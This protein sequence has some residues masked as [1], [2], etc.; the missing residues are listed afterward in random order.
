[1][2]HVFDPDIAERYGVN[3]AIILHSIAFWVDINEKNERNY[4]D[5]RYWTYNSAKAFKD[6]FPYMSV[7]T[8]QRVLKHLIDE[9]LILASKFNGDS[10]NRTNYYALTDYGASLTTNWRV[11]LRQNGNM[12]NDKV[13]TSIFNNN[14]DNSTDIKS[15]VNNNILSPDVSVLD[16]DRKELFNQFWQ[17]YPK[18]K[19]KVDKGGCEKAFI[20]IKDLEKIFP[21]IMASLESWK[22]EWAKDNGKYIPMP[23]KWINK[24]YWT[25]ENTKSEIEQAIDEVTDPYMNGFLL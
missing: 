10:R 14:T 8:I 17:A 11:A 22:R 15:T 18:S 3:E 13:A 25:V 16:S 19:R 21:S 5:G 23:S 20:K 1:M 4:F 6:Q 24:Q 12:Q 2:N 9:G 7:R